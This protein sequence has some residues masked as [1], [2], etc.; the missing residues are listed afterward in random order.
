MATDAH[1]PVLATHWSS[2]QALSS[3]QSFGVPWQS[4]S[5]QVSSVVQGCWSL[6]APSIGL[7]THAP[8]S[9]SQLPAV[10]VLSSTQLS[11]VPRHDPSARQASSCVHASLSSQLAP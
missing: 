11:A 7:K 10:H 9:G 8:L 4:P 2:V 6:Q 1:F 3:L 5:M